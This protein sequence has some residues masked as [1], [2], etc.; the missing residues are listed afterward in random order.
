MCGFVSVIASTG[1]FAEPDLRRAIG[2]LS[3]RGPDALAVR[4]VLRDS[5]NEVWFAHARLA[6]L[7]LTSDGD[8][9]MV[10]H[11]GAIVF[12]GE[13]Y[14]HR[15]LR[16]ALE[17][18]GDAFR[19]ASDTEVLLA[20]LSRY[21]SSFFARCNA[22]AAF[23]YLDLRRAT[24]L[25]GR[26]RLGKKPI[27]VYESDGVVA[28]ASELK[29]FRALG[30]T[31]TESSV[32]WSYFH[33]LRHVPF[34]HTIYRECRKLHAATTQEFDVRARTFSEPQLYWDPFRTCSEVYK[35]SYADAIAEASELLDD[36]TR[37]RLDADVPVGVF[38]SAGVDST[39]VASSAAKVGGAL[40]AFV[41]KADDPQFDESSDAER[42]A[43]QLGIDCVVLHLRREDY[44]AQVRSL[45][46]FF[47][48]PCAPLS[49]IPQSAVSSLA[50]A[51]VK[52]VLTGDGGDE[53]F[54]GYP[55]FGFPERLWGLR[56]VVGLVPGSR[57]I[58]LS[59][60]GGS[61]AVALTAMASLLAGGSTGDI[62]GKVRLARSVL[63]S[64][65][66]VECYDFFQEIR[67]RADLSVDEQ[68]RLGQGGVLER[69]RRHYP[70]YSWHALEN[71]S[72]QELLAGLEM[73]TSM[74]DEI[75]VKVDRS[76][77]AHSLEARSP[78]LDYR[79]VEF[80]FK[81]PLE[82]KTRQGVYKRILR[83]LCAVRGF[84]HIA[85]RKKSGFGIPAPND[86]PPGQSVAQRWAAQ[87]EHDWKRVFP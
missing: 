45:S 31:L 83:D 29:A 75:L 48:E 39:L 18:A 36:A 64:E 28:F 50:S 20:G 55:W 4:C 65:S 7:D 17:H 70:G 73:V 69:A 19:S 72:L 42:T 16:E 26:D 22:M 1:R 57:R 47:D 66:Q 14:N 54:L 63:S 77:M 44:A 53:I 40:R 2:T 60:L 38:L 85:A 82:F 52:A 46:Y 30:L 76:T 8:Q 49:Q 80:G 74:R 87:V 71:R 9:P 58:L 13:V 33:W 11:G 43:K 32:G 59:L 34:E 79:L 81:L 84:P 62:S 41:V 61:G 68:L 37:L 23:C 12:N 27:Y 21:G 24:L 15:A 78:F 67:P 35:G 6:L 25:V 3:H 86:L 5:S 10:G 51:H 56:R